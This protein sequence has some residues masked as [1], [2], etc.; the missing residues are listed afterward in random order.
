MEVNL[1]INDKLYN[2]QMVVQGNQVTVVL[3]EPIEGGPYDG[4]TVIQ[5][6]LADGKIPHD[7]LAQII[8]ETVAVIGGPDQEPWDEPTED[9]VEPVEPVKVLQPE[10][11]KQA[12]DKIGG[13]FPIVAVTYENHENEEGGFVGRKNVV[14]HV[15]KGYE[16]HEETPNDKAGKKHLHDNACPAI[17]ELVPHS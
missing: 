5:K 16:K 9:E 4:Q 2:G 1:G 15:L 7:V 11:H 8:N 12:G 6:T 13:K 17:I 10:D 14:Y 3:T